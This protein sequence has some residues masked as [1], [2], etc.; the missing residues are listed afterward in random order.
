MSIRITPGTPAT[1][2]A[3]VLGLEN[4]PV[5]PRSMTIP[6]SLQKTLSA[7][8]IEP[9]VCRR[10]LLVDDEMDNLVVLVSL[11]EE[12]WD[13]ET[14]ESGIEA[15]ALMKE[16][17]FD[18][19]IA[20]QRMPGMKGVDLLEAAARIY[21][22]SVR[23]V[24][25]AYTDV[26]PI[27]AAI[28]RGAVYRFLLKPWNPEEMRAA[29][30]DA[31]AFKEIRL[32]LVQ[33]HAA[34]IERNQN[35]RQALR[36]LEQTQE[37][38]LSAERLTNLGRLTS[39]ITHNMNN[40]LMAMMQLVE[41]LG[42]SSDPG[43]H[44]VASEALITV[45]YIINLIRDVN[46]FARRQAMEF[47]FSRV[48]A[49]RLLDEV[50]QF[51]RLESLS[52]DHPVDLVVDPVIVTLKIDPH[53]LK[54]AILA[55]LR[56][57]SKASRPGETI[58]VG[59]RPTGDTS[60]VLEVRDQGCGMDEE[61]LRLATTPFFSRFQPPGLG[62]GLEIARLVADG[63]GGRLELESQPGSGTTARL[64]LERALSEGGGLP[65]H[66]NHLSRIGRH[67]GGAA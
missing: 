17:E 63:H 36:D 62:L 40:Q 7:L 34:L 53:R 57:A 48:S 66:D 45:E 44:Q 55:L 11:L 28:N 3:R 38:L 35:L 30:A 6:A 2:E 58:S 31:L 21:P 10:V 52:Q 46:Q 22:E 14:V 67:S 13:V 60:C 43:I 37:Q 42:S 16:R 47:N 59:L 26:E 32:A 8:G 12:D 15:L 61:T 54:Q 27:A 33:V 25:T 4:E 1:A 49:R 18:L 51:F 65:P 24:L 56:N 64:H 19:I 39:G 29:V 41:R 23:M 20:D 9:P 50:V 5:P